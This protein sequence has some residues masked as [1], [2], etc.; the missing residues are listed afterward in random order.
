MKHFIILNV[1]EKY[2]MTLFY[3]IFYCRSIV[4]CLLFYIHINNLNCNISET[5]NA[6]HLL[7]IAQQFS[8]YPLMTTIVTSREDTTMKLDLIFRIHLIENIIEQTKKSY[9]FC[10]SI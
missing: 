8:I 1:E 4:N 5:I 10:L 2:L 9:Y 3:V 7:K 6:A